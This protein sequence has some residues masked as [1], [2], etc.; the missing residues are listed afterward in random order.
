[1]VVIWRPGD[2]PEPACW[3]RTRATSAPLATSQVRAMR[4]CPAVTLRWLS[5][6]QATHKAELETL[7][8]ALKKKRPGAAASL[9]EGL[10]ATLT[11]TRL[12]ITGS[13]LR[14]VESTNPEESMIQIVRVHSRP[15]KALVIRREG[16]A[17]GCSWDAGRR[18]SLPSRQGLPPVATAGCRARMRDH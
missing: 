1:M 9:R 3:P 14:T 18:R 11:V 10:D 12:G 8:R 4:S 17:L 2:I 15:V 13:L 5:G 6:D 16:A 7:A